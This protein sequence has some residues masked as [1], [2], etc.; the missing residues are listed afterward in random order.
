MNPA[1]F[2]RQLQTRYD[3]YMT[4]E[5]MRPPLAFDMMSVTGGTAE[6]ADA[7]IADLASAFPART[8]DLI[9]RAAQ[10]YAF[11][12]A[13]MINHARQTGILVRTLEGRAGS[14][15]GALVSGIGR[16]AVGVSVVSTNGL[17][18]SW[19]VPPSQAVQIIC[20]VE[21]DMMVLDPDFGMGD[22]TGQ[23]TPRVAFIPSGDQQVIAGVAQI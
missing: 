9:A 1:V 5:R 14:L 3:A 2:R 16:N 21:S 13:S 7:N 17:E 22:W 18:N 11:Y 6:E 15:Q 20:D 19:L 23:R 10:E 8:A 12:E 4:G